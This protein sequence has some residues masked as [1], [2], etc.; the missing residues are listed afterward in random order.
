MQSNAS[1]RNYF[2]LVAV[3]RCQDRNGE[4]LRLLSLACWEVVVGVT[5]SLLELQVRRQPPVPAGHAEAQ[6]STAVLGLRAQTVHRF[7]GQPQ[8][9]SSEVLPPEW[10]L[11]ALCI[12][13]RS[14]IC[15]RR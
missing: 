9:G 5:S 14:D 2:F 10:A 11:R 6:R 8:L 13:Q 15:R 3:G 1:F 4:A 7:L 12:S